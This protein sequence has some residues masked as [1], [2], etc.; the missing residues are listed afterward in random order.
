MEQA[1]WNKTTSESRRSREEGRSKKKRKSKRWKEN[2]TREKEGRKRVPGK[3]RKL[4]GKY[5]K[6]SYRDKG[7]NTSTKCGEFDGRSSS[8]SYLFGISL[9]SLFS[10][11]SLSRAA[12][13]SS[14][15]LI[16]S[17]L[18]RVRPELSVTIDGSGGIFALFD[19]RC[20]VVW[21][22]DSATLD[23]IRRDIA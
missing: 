21:E 3:L 11:F 23:E 16:T 19:S 5:I 12:F 4:A 8:K 6:E 10:S 13:P 14:L 15:S 17:V 22:R 9:L 1:K 18:V 2:K 7:I 20:S